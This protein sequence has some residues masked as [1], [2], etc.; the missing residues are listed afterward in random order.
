[1]TTPAPC[2]RAP[3]SPIA[4]TNRTPNATATPLTCSSGACAASCRKASSPP[5][6]ASGF[7]FLRPRLCVMP[8]R[9]VPPE[10]TTPPDAASASGPLQDVRASLSRISLQG[11]LWWAAS[12]LIVIG[13]TVAALGINGLFRSYV[14][15]DLAQRMQRHLDDLIGAASAT[16]EPLTAA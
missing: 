11:R 14:E 8:L 13:L 4:S 2:S 10:P 15:V 5:C 9:I 1:C 16:V 12:G 3:T 6:A 7:A